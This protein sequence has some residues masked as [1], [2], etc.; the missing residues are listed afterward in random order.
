MV[1]RKKAA[2][3]ARKAAKARAKENVQT[4]NDQK[5]TV[6]EEQHEILSVSDLIKKLPC[7]HGADYIPPRDIIAFV[8]AFRTAFRKSASEARARGGLFMLSEFLPDAH[9]ATMPAFTDVWSDLAKMETAISFYLCRGAEFI[10]DGDEDSA[11]EIAT[12]ARYMEQHIAVG[13]KQ[14]HAR[15]HWVKI[16][17]ISLLTDKHTLVKF[18]RHRI[19][20][21]CLDKEYEEVK[22]IAKMGIC[23]NSQCK[24]PRGVVERSKTK[25]CSR[26]RCATYC[27]RDCQ[28][29]DWS[30]HKPFCDRGAAMIAEFEARQ[31]N[32]QA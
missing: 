1:S 3:K 29:A 31:H 14:T 18:F 9:E 7:K 25:Y 24:F 32:I 13:L 26:C 5:A 8:I 4:R 20:C 2:G 15:V 28:E 27:S 22:H 16:E 11:R 23:H 12:Y 17:E 19:P 30:R 10:R 21:S 6:N